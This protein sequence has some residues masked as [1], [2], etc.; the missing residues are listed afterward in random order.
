M[1]ESHARYRPVLARVLSWVAAPRGPPSLGIRL[2]TT[3]E[4]SME[5]KI[6][7]VS[8]NTTENDDAKHDGS[9]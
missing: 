3:R 4:N 6:Y 9:G 1:P 8:T 2:V 7:V 5:Y